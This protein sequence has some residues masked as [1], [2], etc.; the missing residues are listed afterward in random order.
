MLALTSGNCPVAGKGGG[1]G[2]VGVIVGVGVGV[3][4]SKIVDLKSIS[5]DFDEQICGISLKLFLI[6]CLIFNITKITILFKF[7]S[8]FSLILRKSFMLID[9]SYSKG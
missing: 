2:G 3:S 9:Q 1:L 5:F 4:F 7:S 6:I 8:Y